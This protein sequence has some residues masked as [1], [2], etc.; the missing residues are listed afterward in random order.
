MLDGS[1][2]IEVGKLDV[3]GDSVPCDPQCNGREL[4]VRERVEQEQGAGN[5]VLR[6]PLWDVLWIVVEGK[7]LELSRELGPVGS[8]LDVR[9]PLVDM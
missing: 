6:G 1:T 9:D 4:V 5:R 7:S 2:R 3:V 8:V